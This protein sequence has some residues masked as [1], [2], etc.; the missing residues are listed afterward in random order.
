MLKQ[1][2][3][4]SDLDYW[5]RGVHALAFGFLAAIMASSGLGQAPTQTPAKPEIVIIPPERKT[6][7]G[8]RLSLS[9]GQL[10][11][12]DYFRAPGNQQIDLVVFFHG[13]DWVSEQN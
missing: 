12:P 13:A 3:R 7:P 10:F 6:I 1:T 4:R 2:P 9:L 11:V 8:Q 5:K